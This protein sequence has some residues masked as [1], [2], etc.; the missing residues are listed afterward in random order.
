MGGAVK[1]EDYFDFSEVPDYI[2]I[3]GHRIGIEH[4][5]RLYNEYHS[6]EMIAQEFPGLSLEKIYATLAYYLHNKADVDAY[7][8]ERIRSS[9]ERWRQAQ[10]NPAPMMLKMRAIKEQWEREGRLPKGRGS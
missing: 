8:A 3:Q 5:V 4:V 10:A 1:L 6:P 2:R 9:E 7:M